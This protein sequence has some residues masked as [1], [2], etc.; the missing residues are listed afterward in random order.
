MKRKL[1]GMIFAI[2]VSGCFLTA[3]GNKADKE[4]VVV[5]TEAVIKTEESIA[6]TETE[7]ES[8]ATVEEASTV[9]EEAESIQ[10]ADEAVEERSYHELIFLNASEDVEKIKQ[11]K[12]IR[13]VTGFGLDES[14]YIIDNDNCI[15]MLFEDNKEAI[16]QLKHLEEYG[17]E[18]RIC[19]IKGNFEKGNLFHI[20]RVFK[21]SNRG[22]VVGGYKS[23]EGIM[24]VGQTVCLIKKDGTV[25]KDTIK[26]IE[27]FAEVLNET[28][29]GEQ[30]GIELETIEKDSIEVGDALVAWLEE[31]EVEETSEIDT[32][33]TSEE[34]LEDESEQTEESTGGF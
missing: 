18:S 14:K 7:T 24:K 2:A 28:I 20:S 26:C 3:C 13:E 29:P 23:D 32:E 9:H 11:I 33:Q 30:L 16:R 12:G 17:V 31:A 15:M 19:D 10:E 22:T 6:P 25:I 1:F 27:K 4:T 8:T 5:E 34:I 21:L